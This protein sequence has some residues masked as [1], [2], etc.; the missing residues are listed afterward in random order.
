[1]VCNA[2]TMGTPLPQD[3]GPVMFASLKRIAMTLSRLQATDTPLALATSSYGSEARAGSRLPLS[4]MVRNE[5]VPLKR[6]RSPF[7]KL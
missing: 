1:M 6:C 2:E 5:I 7:T 4:L 3:E